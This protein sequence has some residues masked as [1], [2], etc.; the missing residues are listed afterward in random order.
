MRPELLALGPF[1]DDSRSILAAIR[2]GAL[3]SVKLCLNLV[4]WTSNAGAELSVAPFAYTNGRRGS[5]YDSELPLFHGCSL[6]HL[7]EAA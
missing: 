5:L 6:A 3:V 2:K 4:V 7:A 1:A